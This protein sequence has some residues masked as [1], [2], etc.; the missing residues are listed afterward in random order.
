[1]VNLPL[2]C[3]FEVLCLGCYAA[4]IFPSFVPKPLD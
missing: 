2:P 4:V 1:L 3:L